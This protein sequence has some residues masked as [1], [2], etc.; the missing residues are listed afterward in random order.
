MSLPTQHTTPSEVLYIVKKLPNNKAPGHDLIT[1]KIVK[2]LPKKAII[3][4]TYFFNAILRLFYF[5]PT[6]KHLVIILVHRQGKSIDSP[7]SYRPISLLPV[8][9]KILKKI[10]PERLNPT[11]SS[12]NVVP[13]SQFGFKSKHS[14]IHQVH[15]IVDKISA[16]LEKKQFCISAFLDVAQAFDRI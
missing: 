15:I 13:H 8:F 7:S 12:I 5:P 14:S 4:L 10:I 3:L 1:N 11:I 16:A 2:H 6:W 9:S